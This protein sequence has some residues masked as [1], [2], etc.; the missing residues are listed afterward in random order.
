MMSKGKKLGMDSL[1]DKL[2]I[3][4]FFVFLTLIFLLPLVLLLS[5]S[6]S[7][8]TSIIDFGF[9][10][11]P[12]ETSVEAYKFIFRNPDQ[13]VKS[14]FVTI[15]VTAI[16]TFTAMTMMLMCA[17]TLARKGFR[18]KRILSLYIFFTMLF[19][20]G[21][22]PTF[23]LI[24]RYLHMRNT[25]WALV[26][27]AMVNVWHVFILRTFI[28]G[29]SESIIES[30]IID[31][32]SEFKVFT[33]IILPLSKPA[34]ATIG[35]FTLLR[36]WN[37]WMPALL[38]ITEANLFPLQYLLQRTLQSLQEILR[39]MDKMP[40]IVG[41]DY[42]VPSESVRMAMAVVAAG[43]MLF[44]LPFFQ[45]YFVRGMTIGAVKG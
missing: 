44:I 41:S 13:I 20:G 24:T 27:S 21:L 19:N 7:S 9:R 30:A 22:V 8:E 2:I 31:G 4:G 12:A 1:R 45:K 28:Q 34:I 10:L 43:P 33:K 16:G 37:A 3:H 32:A 36:Y 18:Y 25:I 23:I 42:K 14:Y 11:L 26:F 5:I 6:F 17:Y 15:L 40:S 35:L 29:I 38:Y 39:N